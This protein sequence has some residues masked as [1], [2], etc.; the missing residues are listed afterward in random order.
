[1]VRI[2]IGI[3]LAVAAVA[4]RLLAPSNPAL[5]EGA[6]S[7]GVY[8]VVSSLLNLKKPQFGTMARLPKGYATIMLLSHVSG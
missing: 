3:V 5:V 2:I 6:F 8:P 1:M 4:M 7:R